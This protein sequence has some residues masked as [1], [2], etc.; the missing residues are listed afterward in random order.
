MEGEH[1]LAG[2]A[3]VQPVVRGVRG[4]LREHLC[5]HSLAQHQVVAVKGGRTSLEVERGTQL[6]EPLRVEAGERFAPPQPECLRVLGGGTFGI[7]RPMGQIDQLPK[8][9]E[10]HVHGIHGQEVAA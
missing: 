7:V 8:P 5:V 2:E 1:Q 9:V 10:V 3:F 4:E 6:V